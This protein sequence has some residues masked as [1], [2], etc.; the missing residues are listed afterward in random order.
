MPPSTPGL[1]PPLALERHHLK[2]PNVHSSLQAAGNGE[3]TQ[4]VH[5]SL[6]AGYHHHESSFRDL[7]K[8]DPATK[9][10]GMPV[11]HYITRPERRGVIDALLHI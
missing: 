11:S 6:Q 1:L 10:A 7:N 3:T 4:R 2:L 5:I 8:D 9:A